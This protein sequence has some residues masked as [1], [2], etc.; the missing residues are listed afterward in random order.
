MAVH[1]PGK[2]LLIVRTTALANAAMLSWFHSSNS[3]RSASGLAGSHRQFAATS[4]ASQMS[5]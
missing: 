1:A 3:Q 5:W 4:Y 2:T